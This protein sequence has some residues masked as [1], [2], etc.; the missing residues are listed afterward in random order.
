MTPLLPLNVAKRCARKAYEEY[1]ASSFGVWEILDTRYRRSLL[2]WVGPQAT[3][4]VLCIFDNHSYKDLKNGWSAH[5][6]RQMEELR[7]RIEKLD[8]TQLATASYPPLAAADKKPGVTAATLFAGVSLPETL[9]TYAM[10]LADMNS[11]CSCTVSGLASPDPGI[12][13][14]FL[15]KTKSL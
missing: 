15:V 4:D 5:R 6:Y 8:G 11:L 14:V 1:S 13:L 12:G 9:V 2:P 7:M 3:D 10:V